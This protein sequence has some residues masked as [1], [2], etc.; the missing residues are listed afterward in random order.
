[1]SCSIVAKGGGSVL[2]GFF[3]VASAREVRF[4]TV[5]LLLLGRCLSRIEMFDFVGS[6]YHQRFDWAGAS[7]QR[8]SH[9]TFE[10]NASDVSLEFIKQNDS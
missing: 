5:A 4:F 1:M 10:N 2:F 8:R 3:D 6:L 9:S 7:H